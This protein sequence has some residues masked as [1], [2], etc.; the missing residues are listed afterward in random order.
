ML[1]THLK[2]F[3]CTYF[4]NWPVC[5]WKALYCSSINRSGL[6][7]G[8][9]DTQSQQLF[10]DSMMWTISW[11]GLIW[12]ISDGHVTMFIFQHRAT[13]K[14]PH[15]KPPRALICYEQSPCSRI[16]YLPWKSQPVLFKMLAWLSASL[17]LTGLYRV[18]Q[19]KLTVCV[20]NTS[21]DVI[22]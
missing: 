8:W 7:L 19:G 18:A 1:L 2:R 4:P 6:I 20:D 15:F 21:L 14:A 11:W 9:W 16:I 12:V 13:V 17:S 10:V 3:G 5:Y 22:E